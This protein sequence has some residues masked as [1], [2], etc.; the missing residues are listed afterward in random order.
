[1]TLNVH[2]FIFDIKQSFKGK[3]FWKY[4]NV[5]NS[6]FKIALVLLMSLLIYDVVANKYYIRDRSNK[7]FGLG[8]SAIT[9]PI[10]AIDFIQENNIRGNV[11]NDTSVGG[12]FI[13]R[14]YPK[15]K[16]FVDGR[17]DFSERY[18]FH[19][20]DPFLWDDIV[21]TYNI[22]YALLGHGWSPNLQPLIRLLYHRSDWVLVYFDYVAAVFVK[23]TPDN[24]H[25]IKNF[26]IDRNTIHLRKPDDRELRNDFPVSQFHIGNFFKTIGYYDMAETEFR[27]CIDRYPKYLEAYLALADMYAENNLLEKAEEAYRN[28]LSIK[29]KCAEA[30]SGLANVY[31]Q[32]L[33]YR[34]GWCDLGSA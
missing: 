6:T 28:A 3:S 20:T 17:M 10:K 2:S 32:T 23:N 1:M 33:D 21:T 9:F 26:R 8:I 34:T 31:T 15:Q 25:I 7:R 11:F 29:A 16:A 24:E 19:H 18:L 5:L 22:N 30:Y 13:W 12:Y 27:T 14:C 4:S